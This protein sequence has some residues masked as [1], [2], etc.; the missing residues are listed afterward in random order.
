MADTTRYMRVELPTDY[1][2][3][4]RVTVYGT[5]NTEIEVSSDLLVTA[6]EIPREGEGY[7]AEEYREVLNKIRDMSPCI[8]ESV[9]GKDRTTLDYIFYDSAQEIIEKYRAYADT[10]KA[11]E[12][13]K[14]REG[15]AV[16]VRYIKNNIVFYYYCNDVVSS[17]MRC[18]TFV[19][20]FTKTE[21]QSQY[22]ESLIEEMKE[23]SGTE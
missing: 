22:I 8:R 5:N 3:T 23:V 18:D 1:E 13:W 10:P 15:S 4:E 17:Y 20:S 19:A 6:D 2:K 16:V 21:Y 12:Y 9:F 14:N 11:G 7:T